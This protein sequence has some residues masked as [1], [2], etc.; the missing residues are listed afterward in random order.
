MPTYLYNDSKTDGT[1]HE[2]HTDTC[3]HLPYS[4]NRVNLGWHINCEE[5]IKEAQRRT[6][7]YDF[8]GCYHCCRECH[9]G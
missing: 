3:Q 7:K 1:F 6:G 9:T 8:D 4:W 5:A 2:V